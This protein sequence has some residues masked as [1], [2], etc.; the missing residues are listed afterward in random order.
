VM[1]PVTCRGCD[2]LAG[3]SSCSI[4]EAHSLMG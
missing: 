1:S 2:K 4:F 3:S